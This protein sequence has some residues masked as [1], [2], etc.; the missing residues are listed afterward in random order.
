[1]SCARR[2]FIG[3]AALALLVQGCVTPMEEIDTAQ[4]L[5]GLIGQMKAAP[6]TRDELIG[7]LQAG[8]R[9]MPGNLVYL[10]AKDAGDPDSIWITE[11]W[12]DQASHQASLA[13]PDVQAAIA[14]ARPILAGFGT[15][16]ETVPL[17]NPA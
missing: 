17:W 14:K 10:I 8:T 15:R 9:G 3:S 1:M 5:Y 12:K 4:P 13:L 6:G 2:E 7:Y 11:V 16:V